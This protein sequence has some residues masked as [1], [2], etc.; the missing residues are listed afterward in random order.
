M[1]AFGIQNCEAVQS[2]DQVNWK[3]VPEIIERIQKPN[4]PDRDYL[5]TDYNA[6]QEDALPAI[7]KAIKE[8]NSEG[9]GRVVIPA[10][11][12]FS[13]GPIHLKSN[14]NLHLSEGAVLKFSESPK[15]YLPQV[16]T[17]WE[18]TEVFNFSPLIYAYQVH[19]VA[20]T[21][22][23][24]LDGNAKNGF[25]TWRDK[26][27]PAQERLREMGNK[28]TALYERVFGLD[29]Y[30]RPSMIQ[31]FGSSQILVEDVT[32][33]NS[34]M[35]VNH[36]IYS[37]NIIVRGITI[38]SYR[39][40]NDGIDI[41][42]STLVLIE[43]CKISTGDD[44]IVIKSGR[45]QDGWRV[46]RPSEDIVIRNNYM[47]GHNALAI[48]SEM[49]GGVSNV[50]MENNI[51]GEV[52][53]AIYFKSNLDRGGYIENVRVRNIEVEEAD[54]LLRFSTNYHSHRGGDYPTLYRNFIIEEITAK[55]TRLAIEAV[56]LAQL[57][58]QDILVR[59]VTVNEA[60][61]VQHINNVTNFVFENVWVNGK[62][63]KLTQH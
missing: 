27:K 11:E 62:E 22:E 60:E 19:N 35:W 9:G 15:D 47:E 6:A 58:I 36:F 26:Q 7:R 40:N 12:W 29:D 44:S 21:G 41:D 45:D 17:R 42:S 8:A 10:G 63:V 28:G 34:P 50:F 49:S 54:V 46:G 38:E 24:I 32:I 20:I 53:S 1:L 4:F 33:Y 13:K 3:A 59:N 16:L 31:F 18:G 55:K 52:L 48:G 25:G 61:E 23:G 43:D 57:P 14:I 30:L 37:S 5:I 2:S 56:G 51:L 39:L